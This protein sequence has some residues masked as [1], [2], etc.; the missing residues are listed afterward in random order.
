MS[1]IKK[2]SNYSYSLSQEDK[3]NDVSCHHRFH[4]VDG[5]KWLKSARRKLFMEKIRKS[6]SGSRDKS[7]DRP[8]QGQISC[9]FLLEPKC[10]PFFPLCAFSL[11]WAW[12]LSSYVPETAKIQ[13]FNEWFLNFHFDCASLQR[14]KTIFP[15]IFFFGFYPQLIVLQRILNVPKTWTV[16]LFFLCNAFFKAFCRRFF[17]NKFYLLESTEASQTINL[18]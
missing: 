9:G 13:F 12:I 7:S 3:L 14:W 5:K 6:L 4:I 17:R 2:F 10:H 15:L 16:E 8:Q 18:G 1:C 11:L